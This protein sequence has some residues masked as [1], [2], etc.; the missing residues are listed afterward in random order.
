MST[1]ATW[2]LDDNKVLRHVKNGEY[3]AYIEI[4][5]NKNERR[6]WKRSVVKALDDLLMEG[7]FE[8]A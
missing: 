7:E 8:D 4:R 5:I 2:I 1:K 6:N 3:V